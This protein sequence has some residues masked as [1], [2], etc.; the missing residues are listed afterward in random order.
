MTLAEIGWLAVAVLLVLLLLGIRWERRRQQRAR[1]PA[2]PRYAPFT[3]T[4]VPFD[5]DVP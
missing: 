5:R 3:P 4:V 2:E 1:P